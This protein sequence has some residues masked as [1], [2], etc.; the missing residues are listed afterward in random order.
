[1]KD[2]ILPHKLT[3]YDMISHKVKNK[4]GHPIFVFD[5]MKVKIIFYLVI[6][7]FKVVELNMKL[8]LRDQGQQK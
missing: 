8:R 1:M 4:S 2:M 5:K 6:Y 3:F 7:R